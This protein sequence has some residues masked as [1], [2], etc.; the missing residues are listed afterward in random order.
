MTKELDP[1]AN[2]I[3][4]IGNG[5][6][7]DSL[8]APFGNEDVIPH[9]MQKP[10]QSTYQAEVRRAKTT[11]RVMKDSALFEKI[12]KDEHG[13]EQKTA[14]FVGERASASGQP[15]RITGPAKYVKGY[16]DVLVTAKLLRRFP[17]GHNNIRLAIAHPPD[18]INYV[19]KIQ[20]VLGG[21]YK[22][23]DVN[24]NTIKWVIRE[25]IPWDECVGG[26]LR[27]LTLKAQG[28]NPLSLD[29]G[30]RVLLV[31]VGSQV[32]TMTEILLDK[33]KDDFIINPM[34]IP[35]GTFDLGIQNVAN[36]LVDELRGLYPD[37]FQDMRS[38]PLNMLEEAMLKNQ[39]TLAGEPF[40]CE[41]AV[42]NSKGPILDRLQG[43][44]KNYFRNGRNFNH[45]IVTGGGGG[46]L[47]PSLQGKK[48]GIF[49]HGHVH[50]ADT[51]DR[52]H[53]ANLRG[54]MEAFKRWIERADSKQKVR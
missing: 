29:E 30:M 52:I 17:K 12:T 54:Q 37:E 6:M 8:L 24:G 15:I 35:E 28:Y 44:Y 47:F 20:D 48:E 49:R 33:E 43:I 46:L 40:N 23:I 26:I 7:K 16:F 32:S 50:L 38:V 4:D 51:I 25:I 10:S 39:V 1:V 11:P 19:E 2:W 34:F 31:D 22:A 14:Y 53:L 18:A 27:F 3:A 13:I 42:L 36:L 5:W 45:I 21:T 9:V 41:Q